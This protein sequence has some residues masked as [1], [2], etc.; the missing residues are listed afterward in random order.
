MTDSQWQQIRESVLALDIAQ[1]TGWAMYVDGKVQSGVLD[2][3]SLDFGHA[4]HVFGNW[5]ADTL[6]LGIGKLVIETPLSF[7][8]T[9]QSARCDGLCMIAHSTAHAHDVPRV[10]VEAKAW[11]KAIL[12]N[13]GLKRADAKRLAMTWAKLEGFNP[14]TDDEAEALAIMTWALDQREAA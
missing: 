11:R 14:K 10:E 2:M 5:L 7:R 9:L 13:G 1:K 4:G 3:S 12:G 8:R 6:T